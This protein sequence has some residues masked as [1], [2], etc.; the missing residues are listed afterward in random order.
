MHR[1]GRSM[2]DVD[3]DY[4]NRRT[5][6]PHPVRVRI[7]GLFE[8]TTSPLSPGEIAGMLKLSFEQAN[9][10]VRVLENSDLLHVVRTT[11][12][13]GNIEMFYGR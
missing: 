2:G 9:Y 5:E 7:W 11:G 1:E 6:N 10:H 12:S 13:G 8:A 3:S 4:A